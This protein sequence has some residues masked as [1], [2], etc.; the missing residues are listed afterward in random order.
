MLRP[1]LFFESKRFSVTD[2]EV[3]ILIVI[4]W[5]A[6]NYI[7]KL[8]VRTWSKAGLSRL[9]NCKSMTFYIILNGWLSTN[10]FTM[11][12]Q[13]KWST[14]NLK[15]GKTVVGMLDRLWF[16]VFYSLGIYWPFGVST[17]SMKTFNSWYA[18]KHRH[19]VDKI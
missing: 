12:S 11:H 16:P 10:D 1:I 18:A 13:I 3:L 14:A 5:R 17:F 19:V 8:Q 15:R 2:L 7:N 4:S 9:I 6:L